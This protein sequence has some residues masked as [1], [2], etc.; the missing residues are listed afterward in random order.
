MNSPAQRVAGTHEISNQVPPFTNYN[1]F[2]SDSTL[3]N[4]VEREG[5]GWAR[6]QLSELGQFLGAEEAQR[7]GFD[8]NE[9]E[10]AL[11]THDRYGN[12]RDEV[13]FHPSW[14]SLMQKSVAHKIHSLP[15]LERG[16]G[17]QVGPGLRNKKRGTEPVPASVGN[18]DALAGVEQGEEV[19][20][21]PARLNGTVR[22]PGYVEV[23]QR[24]RNFGD[25]SLLNLLRHA[26]FGFS[27][28]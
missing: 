1:L 17:A 3:L 6:G 21:V 22:C 14:H 4:A 23:A 12:R 2:L 11:H 24:G 25:E 20:I 7:W 8:A 15:W 27:Q 10:P 13:I 5:A 9:N 28:E 19:E 18:D 16:K 26:E